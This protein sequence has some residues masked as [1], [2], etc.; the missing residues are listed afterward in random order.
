MKHFATVVALALL[1]LTP[2]PPAQGQTTL[3]VSA[4]LNR[5]SVT[6]SNRPN[7]VVEPAMRISIGLAAGISISEGWNAE[8]G[9]SYSQKP[10]LFMNLRVEGKVGG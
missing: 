2:A 3:L 4:G 5:A 1:L 10:G 7:E 6:I 9:A 8:L